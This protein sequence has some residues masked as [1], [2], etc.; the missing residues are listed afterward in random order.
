MVTPHLPKGDD[1]KRKK[2]VHLTAAQESMC[3]CVHVCGCLCESWCL[4]SGA[5]D[6]QIR[7]MCMMYFWF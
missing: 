3:A 1:V 2:H 6:G 5:A 7:G 4:P